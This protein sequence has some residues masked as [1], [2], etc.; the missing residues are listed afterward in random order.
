M[1][2]R[3]VDPRQQTTARRVARSSRPSWERL[4]GETERLL[5][6]PWSLIVTKH[7]DWGRNAMFAMATR[8]L[9]W[10]LVEL[11]RDVPGLGYAAAAQ[12][13]RNFRATAATRPEMQ[14]F[15]KAV[16]DIV[17]LTP[18]LF[19][20]VMH[21]QKFLNTNKRW[22]MGWELKPRKRPSPPFASIHSNAVNIGFISKSRDGANTLDYESKRISANK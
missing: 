15:A 16:I 5:G 12:G 7:G 10:K 1:K 14:A 13:V 21:F 22:C 8:H 17:D 9:G 11:V 20:S 4:G 19:T 2:G 18:A 6:R 3:E